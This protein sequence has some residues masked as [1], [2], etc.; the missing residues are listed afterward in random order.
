M[1]LQELFDALDAAI[2]E[3]D[4]TRQALEK[5]EQTTAAAVAKAQALLNAAT[6]DAAVQMQQ[7]QAAYQV[8]YQAARDLQVEFT[9]RTSGMLDAVTSRVRQ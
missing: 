1:T 8:N 4:K 2:I 3:V 9:R 5:A 6:A 7:A